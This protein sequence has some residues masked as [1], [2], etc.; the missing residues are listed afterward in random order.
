MSSV[1]RN[2]RAA[3]ARLPA[4]LAGLPERIDGYSAALSATFVFL[5]LCLVYLATATYTWG[6]SPDPVAAGVP[7]WQLVTHGNLTL[8][9][10]EGR[11]LWFV[12]NGERVV[13]NRTPGVI[14]FA[15]P[16]YWLVGTDP[17]VPSLV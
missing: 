6:V 4:A 11:L 5:F 10:F 8:D 12:D 17:E 13:S 15:V 14:F 7:A 1:P 2:L 9:A 3:R 16:F